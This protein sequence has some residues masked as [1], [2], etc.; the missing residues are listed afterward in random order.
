LNKKKIIN[1]P[2]YGFINVSSELICD[3]IDHRYFQRL[4]RIKQTGLTELV[5]PGSV[6]SRFHHAI[7]SMHLMSMALDTL[8]RK[9]VFLYEQ[10]IQAALIAVLLHDIG[11][12]PFSHSLEGQLINKSHEELSELLID[13]LNSEFNGGLSMS[14]QIFQ[15]K[16]PRNFF[17][18]LVSSQLD[19]DRL[20]YLMRDSFFTGVSEGKIG[21]DR[22]LKLIHVQNDELVVEEK[23]IYNIE[24][25]LNARRLMYWQVYFHKTGLAAEGMLKMAVKRGRKLIREGKIKTSGSRNLD[26]LLLSFKGTV[27]EDQVLKFIELDDFDV[28]QALKLWSKNDDK[29]LSFLCSSILNRNLFRMIVRNDPFDKDLINKIRKELTARHGFSEKEVKYLVFHGKISNAAYTRSEESIKIKMKDGR[30]LDVDQA[31]DLPN[32]KAMGKIVSKRFL[33]FPK[34]VS[35]PF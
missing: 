2:V 27:K 35:L 1:D 20:D 33:C 21:T 3:I 17:N 29:V 22:I 26:D 32:I 18:Q 4:R 31:A 7:G 24:N 13:E 16:Y 19:V 15:K 12:G 30:L 10:E 25:F 6:H 8:R 9:G 23:G 5:Y 14:K 34:Y 11:H 28:W